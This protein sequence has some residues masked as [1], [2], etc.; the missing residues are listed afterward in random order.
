MKKIPEHLKDHPDYN[1]IKQFFKLEEEGKDP[2][3][4]L[5]GRYTVTAGWGGWESFTKAPDWNHTWMD[6]T[7]LRYV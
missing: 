6:I 1:V 7:R 4:N 3:K 5:E 2:I